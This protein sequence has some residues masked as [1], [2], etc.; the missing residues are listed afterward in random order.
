MDDY[1]GQTFWASLK[2]NQLLPEPLE[3]YWPDFLCVTAGYGG[4]D[5]LT[6]RPYRVYFIGL[7]LDMTKVIPDDT[8]FLK[9]LGE[10][11]NFI[12]LPAPAVRISPTV[13]W[14]GLYF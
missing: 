14:Y 5:I 6:D 13:I 10:A 9:T 12:R 1:E 11:L 8:W 2:V 4:R 3:H 7:D